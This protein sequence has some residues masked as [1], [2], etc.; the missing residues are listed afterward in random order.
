MALTRLS[1]RIET[2]DM[3]EETRIKRYGMWG[4][5]VEVETADKH[6]RIVYPNGK[7][8]KCRSLE[9]AE[10]RLKELVEGRK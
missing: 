8:E 9:L 5:N 1:D 4:T 6:F 7:F 3:G 10:I 2:N